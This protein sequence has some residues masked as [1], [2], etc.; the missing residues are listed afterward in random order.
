MAIVF[1]RIL[2]IVAFATTG[3]RPSFDKGVAVSYSVVHFSLVYRPSVTF[4]PVMVFE[5]RQ[6]FSYR[7]VAL[8]VSNSLV[9]PVVEILLP[10]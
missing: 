5:K 3:I 8:K 9:K 7:Q 1:E 2:Y 6:C 10:L 4:S